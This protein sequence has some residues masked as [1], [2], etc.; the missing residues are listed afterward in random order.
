MPDFLIKPVAGV[1]LKRFGQFLRTQNLGY[2][3]YEQWVDQRC[4]PEL[5]AGYKTA[6]SVSS[7]G[8]IVGGIV[9]QKHKCLIGT[10]EIKNLRVGTEFRRRDLAH[11]LVKQAE[12]YAKEEKYS[13]MIADFRA[14]KTYSQT[15]SNFLK[16]C[17]FEV[18]FQAELYPGGIDYIVGKKLKPKSD[19]LYS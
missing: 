19:I 5:D 2:L 12:V 7:N 8:V 17:G 13:Q 9:F 6:Y 3:G 1:D 18:L 16:F 11:F 14:D 4:L 10:L 15:L